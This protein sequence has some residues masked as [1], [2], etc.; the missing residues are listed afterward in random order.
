[1]QAVS[2]VQLVVRDHKLESAKVG[3]EPLDDK[4]TYGVATINFLLTGG[5]GLFIAKNAL[6][7]IDS[8]V[9][10]KDAVIPYI[11][12]LTRESTAIEGHLDDRVV[13]YESEETKE[14]EE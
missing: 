7:L 10:V 8:G 13:V 1:M 11:Q 2:G 4:K 9:M 12:R 3:G 6:E 5:D 14:G